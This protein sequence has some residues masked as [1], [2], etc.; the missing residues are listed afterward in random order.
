MITAESSRLQDLT[1]NLNSRIEKL[2]DSVCSLESGL[3]HRLNEMCSRTVKEL[4]AELETAAGAALAEF[5]T[6]S[7]Q[8]LGD[9]LNQVRA[10][11]EAA[12]KDTLASVSE[13]LDL[14]TRES[15]RVFEKSLQDVGG[16]SVEGWRLKIANGLSAL[17]KSLSE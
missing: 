2:E 1:A 9:E 5:T 3:D 10:K 13:S 6:R 16:V 11:M 8:A 4:R 15:L 7:G 14:R 17:A 12:Q